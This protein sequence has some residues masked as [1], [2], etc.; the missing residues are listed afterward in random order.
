MPFDG[1]YRVAVERIKS[2]MAT[3][4]VQPGVSA[5]TLVEGP[6]SAETASPLAGSTLSNA[7]PSEARFRLSLNVQAGMP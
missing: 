6:V 3:L 4:S 7:S 1:N 5:V 2:F